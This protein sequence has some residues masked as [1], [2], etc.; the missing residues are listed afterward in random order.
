MPYRNLSMNTKYKVKT[1]TYDSCMHSSVTAARSQNL[2]D[3]SLTNNSLLPLL[4]DLI[5]F[6]YFLQFEQK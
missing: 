3:N 4:T 1:L 2:I 6:S 5:S